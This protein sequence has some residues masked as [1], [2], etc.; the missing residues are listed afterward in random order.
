M[1]VFFVDEILQREIN[2][3]VKLL[4]LNLFISGNLIIDLCLKVSHLL[5]LVIE[6][7]SVHKF[8]IRFICNS[9]GLKFIDCVFVSIVLTSVNY[10]HGVEITAWLFQTLA[11]ELQ[12]YFHRVYFLS[13][14][15]FFNRF[16]LELISKIDNWVNHLMLRFTTL[17]SHIFLQLVL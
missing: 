16:I 5:E 8:R 10:D 15:Y 7:V 13:S 14:A 11:L 12:L 6:T 2:L 3:A 4:F 9:L 1:A 17:V